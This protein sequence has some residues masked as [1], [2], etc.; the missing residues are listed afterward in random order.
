MNEQFVVSQPVAKLLKEAGFPQDDSSTYWCLTG[1]F[2]TY[3][4]QRVD[5][6]VYGTRNYFKEAGF[7]GYAAP[8]VGRLGKELLACYPSNKTDCTPS[9]YVCFDNTL[10]DINNIK[11]IRAKSEAD[12]R[13]LMWIELKKR[14]IV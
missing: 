6:L 1:N 7:E 12:C 4:L 10:I 13:A 11:P 14:G 2:K 8:C 3:V 5:Q 9:D